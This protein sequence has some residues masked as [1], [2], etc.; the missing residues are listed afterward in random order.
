[1]DFERITPKWISIINIHHHRGQCSFCK[2]QG[3]DVQA[4]PGH[5]KTHNL[6]HW[7]WY[8]RN[9]CLITFS[10]LFWM[11]DWIRKY[12]LRLLYIC[13]GVNPL[14]WKKKWIQT[15]KKKQRKNKNQFLKKFTK[16]SFILLIQ[17]WVFFKKF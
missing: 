10:I 2:T 11:Y 5:T 15:S 6:N 8:M 13:M 14:M 1:M 12:D 9:V 16:R 4:D 3:L 7:H 17:R